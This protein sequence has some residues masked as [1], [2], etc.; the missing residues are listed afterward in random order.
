MVKQT[1]G[2]SVVQ[3]VKVVKIGLMVHVIVHVFREA[4]VMKDIMIKLMVKQNGGN[5]VQIVRVEKIGQTIYVI[6]HVFQCLN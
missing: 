1:G 6:V 2:G 5:V 4:L 3:I